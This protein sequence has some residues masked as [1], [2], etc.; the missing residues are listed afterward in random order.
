MSSRP[1]IKPGDWIT[2][3]SKHIDAYV[4]RVVSPEHLIAGYVQ[5]GGKAV[6]EAVEFRSGR[7]EFELSGVDATYLSSSEEL[8]VRRGPF[9]P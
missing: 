6:R 2:V 4:F 1:D 3:G 5:H 7:W 9:R 8:L